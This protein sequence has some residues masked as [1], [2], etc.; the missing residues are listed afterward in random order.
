MQS[1]E[2]MENIKKLY[3]KIA[4]R[5]ESYYILNHIT[6]SI[7][8]PQIVKSFDEALLQ[9]FNKL[10]KPA[11]IACFIY[12]L[13]RIFNYVTTENTAPIRVITTAIRLSFFVPWA[14]I[15]C[16]RYRKHAPKIAFVYVVF[17]LMMVNLSYR[18]Q[19]PDFMIET[20][21]RTD[22]TTI[23]FVL[24]TFHTMNYNRFL[25]T[26]VLLPLIVLPAFYAQIQ[27]EVTM[28]NDPYTRE[29]LEGA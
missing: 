15:R 13:V 12:L 10:F 26:A 28:W 21:R 22:E 5:K 20:D 18:D 3:T 2:N 4:Y 11:S 23:I 9:N 29:P 16:T 6:L 24:L 8:D 14:L 25:A 7:S 17:W 19:V 27:I 1:I